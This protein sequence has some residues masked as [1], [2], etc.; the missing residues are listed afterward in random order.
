MFNFIFESLFLF[1]ISMLFT[2]IGIKISNKNDV[3]P[4]KKFTIKN[5]IISLLFI[6]FIYISIFIGNN[7]SSKS[8]NNLY[9]K[10]FYIICFDIYI[11]KK[12][13]SYQANKNSISNYFKLLNNAK[14]GA[15]FFIT[16]TIIASSSIVNN[17]SYFSSFYIVVL[18]QYYDAIFYLA[19]IQNLNFF[20][21]FM[22]LFINAKSI[23]I[24]QLFN[25]LAI[26]ITS[27]IL[28]LYIQS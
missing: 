22:Y 12:L 10:L 11:L 24:I 7:F 13:N 18:A 15:I 14:V 1:V 28:I 25:D 5:V 23:L 4:I 20:D 27:S 8:Y 6:I 9:L 16:F 26:Y 3:N 2:R 17:L 21:K 19:N